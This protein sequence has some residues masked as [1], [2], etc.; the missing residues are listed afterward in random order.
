[1]DNGVDTIILGC[2]HYPILKKAIGN[3]V[4]ENVKLIDS[5]E[6]TA[7]Y[8]VSLICE[9]NLATTRTTQGT[10]DYYVSDHVENFSKIAGLFLGKEINKD[11]QRIHIEHY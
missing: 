1:M 5:G 11:V 3:V 4:G 7:K 9:N 2:T 8:A 6:E 10:C